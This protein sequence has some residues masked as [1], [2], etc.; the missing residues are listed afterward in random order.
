MAKISG[1]DS[2]MGMGMKKRKM[3]TE[4]LSAVEVLSG[5]ENMQVQK[6]DKLQVNTVD[7][8]IIREDCNDSYGDDYDD[9]GQKSS[10]SGSGSSEEFFC[11]EY[12]SYDW[13]LDFL[14][15]VYYEWDFYRV[16]LYTT[17]N[18]WGYA[19]STNYGYNIFESALP[20]NHALDICA[21][22]FGDEFNRTRV[23]LGVNNMQV[24]YGGADAYNGTNVFFVNGSEDPWHYLGVY[25]PLNPDSVTSLLIPGASHCEDM[26]KEKDNDVQPL[27]DA[28]TAIKA[29]INAWVDNSRN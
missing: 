21:D 12:I 23:D 25:A 17:C 11:W 3:T 29:Q 28:R 19:R 7:K 9:C 16:W 4:K 14:Q 10:D 24:M 22:I 8:R 5:K 18:E 20:I 6:A 1:D 15:D 13:E 27:I 26:N 2:Y